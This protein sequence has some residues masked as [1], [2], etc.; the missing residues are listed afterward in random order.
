M[1]KKFAAAFVAFALAMAVP[2]A[3]FADTENSISAQPGGLPGQST[4]DTSEQGNGMDS[5]TIEGQTNGVYANNFGTDI[6]ASQQ[7][8][9]NYA[10]AKGAAAAEKAQTAAEQKY[11]SQKAQLEAELAYYQSINN[12]QMVAQINAQLAAIENAIA[13]AA[14]DAQAYWEQ[15]AK[16]Y[17][18]TVGSFANINGN[19]VINTFELQGTSIGSSMTVTL[20]LDQSK[21]AGHTVTIIILNE[22]GTITKSTQVVDANGCIKIQKN[23][24]CVWT[25]VDCSGGLP[26]GTTVDGVSNTDAEKALSV[27]GNATDKGT[28]PKTGF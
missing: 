12:K 8:A 22:D 26:A 4:I 25:L 6:E 16:N 5:I 9:N 3:A 1:K 2:A 15:A 11:A 13:Q 10:E 24:F 20:V 18:K 21:Y 17:N 19:E 7:N 23:G 28:S 14:E 27:A